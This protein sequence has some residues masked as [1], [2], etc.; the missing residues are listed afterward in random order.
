M[1]TAAARA[2]DSR[3]RFIEAAIRLFA[4]HSFAGTSLQ[5]IADEVGVTKSA[6][7]H[8]FRTR[9]E[10]ITA[11]VEPL[12][13]ELRAALDTAEAQRSRPARAEHMLAGFVDI[14]VRS[15]ELVP[16]LAGDPGT[17]EMVRSNADM[18]DVVNRQIAIFADLEPGPGGL[19]KARVAMAGIACGL[20]PQADEFDDA[21][22]RKHLLEA[23]RRTLGLRTP[24]YSR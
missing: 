18:N 17:V 10:L 16:L 19:I 7:H 14:V 4:R 22:L 13:H 6:V 21:T 1:A 23:G 9:E 8:H 3:Q 11:V 24:R 20:G 15:R 12:Y 2:T 5:M